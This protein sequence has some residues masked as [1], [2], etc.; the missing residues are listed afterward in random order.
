MSIDDQIRLP[1]GTRRILRRNK[2]LLQVHEL[3]DEVYERV[4]HDSRKGD[5]RRGF[6]ETSHVLVRTEEP[7]LSTWVFVSFHAFETLECVVEDA[8]R[9][10]EAEVLIWRYSRRKPSLRGSPFDREHMVY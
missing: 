8:S 3:R 10:V 4:G 6:V 1:T 9:R 7:D 2:S 5:A